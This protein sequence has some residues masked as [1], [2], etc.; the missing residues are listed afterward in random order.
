MPHFEYVTVAVSIVL[1]LGVVRLLDGVHFAA[2]R[3]R[4]HWVLFLWTLTK[5]LNHA[6]YW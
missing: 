1:S 6:L 3:E 2:S 4:G 5:L